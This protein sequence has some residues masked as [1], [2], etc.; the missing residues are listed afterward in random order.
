[1]SRRTYSPNALEPALLSLIS[2]GSA[3]IALDSVAGLTAP[4]YMVIDPDDIAKREYFKFTV[5]N[6]SALEG[7]TRGLV[8]SAAGAVGHDANAPCRQVFTSQA[9]DDIFEDIEDLEVGITTWVAADAAHVAAADPHTVYLEKAGDTMTGELALPAGDPSGA[10][11]AAHKAYVDAQIAGGGL[12][13]GTR[14]IFDQ[15]T[16]PAGWTRDVATVNDRMIMIVTGARGVDDGTWTQPGHTHTNPN[17][18]TEAAHS[19]V[20]PIHS[21]PIVAHTHDIDPHDHTTP[22]TGVAIGT[23]TAQEDGGT[24][25]SYA[26]GSHTHAM[27]NTGSDDPFTTAGGS[28]PN[29]SLNTGGQ[30]GT[31][32]GHDHTVGDSGGAATASSW[33]PLH[34]DMILAVKD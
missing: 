9:L 8:G 30:T 20:D 23:A 1:M 4:G 3:S 32:G 21:H 15:D 19:H 34:R 7:L 24:N 10:T 29:T 18:A 2:G 17:T 31:G 33:R 27:G 22:N 25:F 13:V 26:I 28:T 14:M 16:A 5:I 6:G 11:V 12:P